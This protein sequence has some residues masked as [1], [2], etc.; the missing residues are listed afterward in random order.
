MFDYPS[1]GFFALK[2]IISQAID[3]FLVFMFGNLLSTIVWF[4]D[5]FLFGIVVYN[6]TIG[7][8][9]KWKHT[10]IYNLLYL[11]MIK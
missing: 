11:Q 4:R 3:V 9:K 10:F 8:L 5:N 2:L 6:D 1:L 7:F